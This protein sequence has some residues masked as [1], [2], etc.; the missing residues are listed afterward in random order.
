MRGCRYISITILA[1]GLAPACL[2]GPAASRA[3]AA[4]PD[5]L[6]APDENA[7]PV[8]LG[9]FSTTLIGSGQGRTHNIRLACAALDG[10]DA[11]PYELKV[12]LA[13]GRASVVRSTTF[14]LLP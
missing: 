7:F 1:L 9:S 5:S 2:M 12:T 11:G 3:H 8:V 6:A 14:D 10:I 13:D 4:E